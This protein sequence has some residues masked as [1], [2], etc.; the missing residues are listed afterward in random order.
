LQAV[1][2]V[3]R[4]A[5]VRCSGEDG[6]LVV[7]EDFQPVVDVAGVILANFRRDAEIGTEKR[8]ASSPTSSS[9]V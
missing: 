7:F 6:P 9:T 8:G 2:E 1:Q 3:N 5:G 4:L